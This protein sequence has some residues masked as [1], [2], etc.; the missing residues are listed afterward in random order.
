MA[1]MI[2]ENLYQDI[3]LS[4]HDTHR[5]IAQPFCIHGSTTSTMHIR[6]TTLNTKGGRGKETYKGQKG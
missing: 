4:S 3:F 1:E 2:E 6:Y 5:H